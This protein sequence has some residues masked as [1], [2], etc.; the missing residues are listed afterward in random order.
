MELLIEFIRNSFET[1]NVLLKFTSDT[2]PRE[3]GIA[4][5]EEFGV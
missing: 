1:G 2:K 4:G 3:G 5:A